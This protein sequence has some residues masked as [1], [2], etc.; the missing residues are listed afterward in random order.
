MNL[1]RLGQWSRRVLVA[2][3]CPVT[4][5]ALDLTT[6]ASLR[7]NGFGT[8]GITSTHGPD[9]TGYR[10]DVSHSNNN[11]GEQWLTDTRLGLQANYAVNPQLELTTQIVL[12]D[13]AKGSKPID[14]LE[15]A[16][17]TY[18]PTGDVTVRV[19]RT[20]P[21]MFLMTDYRN[22]G[23]AYSTVRPNVDFYG[24]LPLYSINGADVAYDWKSGEA[25]WRVKGIVSTGEAR[26]AAPG[27]E[28]VVTVDVQ[29][30]VGAVITREAHGLTLRASM[31]SARVAIKKTA[32]M[33]QLESA[34]SALQ[35]YP[36]P[37]VAAQ[38]H[39]LQRDLG[40]S[41]GRE[42]FAELGF[43]YDAAPWLFSGEIGRISGALGGGGSTAAYLS[44]GRRFDDVTL[45]GIAGRIKPM[46]RPVQAP[47][48]SS[49][50]VP[51]TQMLGQ[52]AA[53][54]INGASFHQ[55]SL[56]LGL[57]WDFHP[58]VALKVQWDQYWV[59]PNGSALWSAGVEREARP[60]VGT[61]LLDFIF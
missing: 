6:S 33:S 14:S 32:E 19:G 26:T 15:W 48:W 58:Q 29:S 40:L 37:T 22:V 56:S 10:R 42:T 12:R 4:A 47:D 36:D 18:R 3:A 50:P 25:R 61:V 35:A 60:Q 44:I 24:T 9:G 51:G 30:A 57:R 52:M 11:G 28:T 39:D 5:Q 23:F 21:V 34:L 16:F 17:V 1:P 45:Y 41:P 43:S 38:A 53:A 7:L 8:V 46:K 13:R 31:T 49:V 54:G 20:S 55:H 59:Q 2:L 27:Q